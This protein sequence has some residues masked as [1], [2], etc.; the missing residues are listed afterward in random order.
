MSHNLTA[1]MRVRYVASRSGSEM[2]SKDQEKK[3]REI[4]KKSICSLIFFAYR[5]EEKGHKIGYN[6]C[7]I[8]VSISSNRFILQR[9]CILC[10]KPNR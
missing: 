6:E 1:F 7:S 10:N 4:K 8:N 5:L 3:S 9:H 2:T